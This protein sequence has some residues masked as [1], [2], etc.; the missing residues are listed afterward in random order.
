MECFFCKFWSIWEAGSV[1]G[2]FCDFEGEAC[3]FPGY[4]K[5]ILFVW[6]GFVSG[7]AAGLAAGA[8]DA[9]ERLRV[10]QERHCRLVGGENR[11]VERVLD[12]W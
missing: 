12:P 2:V 11:C 5:I 6:L 10:R 9:R 4:E 8:C 7:E 3:G 1:K